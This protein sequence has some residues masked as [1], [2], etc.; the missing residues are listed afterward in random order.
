MP[1]YEYRCS[2]CGY[3]NDYLQKLSEPP[4]SDCP[5]CGRSTFRKQVTAAGFQL[6]GT[7]WYAT[8]FKN[9]G[10]SKPGASKDTEGAKASGSGDK[11]G[12][13]DTAGEGGKAGEGAKSGDGAKAS[14]DGGADN[15]A[16][17]KSAGAS[18]AG[19]CHA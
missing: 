12:A 10:T 1:I 2:A 19:A 9:N 14:A 15:A 13:G 6:K 8:D 16:S 3:Q 18:S 11:A 17:G 5:E 7:G 4:L